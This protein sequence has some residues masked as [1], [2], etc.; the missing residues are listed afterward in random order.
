[1]GFKKIEQSPEL[2]R[3]DKSNLE[4][5]SHLKWFSWW[6]EDVKEIA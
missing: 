2:E 3:Y 6:R 5:G 4:P 1:L